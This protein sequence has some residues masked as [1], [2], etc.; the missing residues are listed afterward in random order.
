MWTTSHASPVMEIFWMLR[1]WWYG[2]IPPWTAFQTPNPRVSVKYCLC[3]YFTF[4][5][6]KY[7]LD[8][9]CFLFCWYS[10]IIFLVF[11]YSVCIVNI[12]RA[13]VSF[14]W[15]YCK[16]VKYFTL[17]HFNGFPFLLDPIG[18]LCHVPIISEVQ[19]VSALF[20]FSRSCRSILCFFA[21]LCVF[22]SFFFFF[23]KIE[24]WIEIEVTHY[25]CLII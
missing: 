20:C 2:V 17:L 24:L 13:F 23:Q 10:V 15:F 6:I 8:G 9:L 5:G 7:L 25:T 12:F 3:I 19:S 21:I 16:V 22:L 1:H 4:F 11:M 18:G 14:L